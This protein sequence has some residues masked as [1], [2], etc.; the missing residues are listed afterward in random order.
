MR[1]L[2]SIITAIFYFT[3]GMLFAQTEPASANWKTW[4]VGSV[5]SYRLPAPPSSKEEIAQVLAVQQNLDSAGW[6]QLLF[7]NAG[8]PGYRWHEM[9]A[10]IWQMD[11]GRYGALANMLL[12]TSIYDATVAAWDS[13]YAYNRPRPFAADKR[14][15]ALIY[16]PDSPSYPCEHSVA[17][18][19]AVAVFSH[20]YPHLAD[21]VNRMAQRAMTS[22]MATG[23]AFPSDV[24]AGFEL[25]KRIALKEIEQTQGYVTKEVWDGKMPTGTQ[26]WKGKPMHPLAGKN[27]TVVLD[28]SSQFRP[29]APPDFAKDM[30]ELKA[31]KQTFRSQA[32]AF[33]YASQN[34]SDDILHKKIFEYN[35]HLHPPKAARI[36][37]ATAVAYYETFTACW[38]AKYAYWGLRPNQYDTTYKS[39]LPT[40]P[41]PGY[42]S[43]H[44]M[45][46]GMTGELFSYFFPADRALFQ[47]MAKDGAES[48][49][50][51]GIHFRT[52]NEVG[53]DMGRKVAGAIIRRLKHDGADENK[54]TDHRKLAL[55]KTP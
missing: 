18:G 34:T 45:M 35:L 6:Q 19:A 36:Y 52:D 12:G 24:Q 47:K 5:K 26:Y 17:A 2:F 28:S 39:L 11:T 23:V 42:P 37:A 13:K 16:K 1:T 20:F 55:V 43:G 21:S 8:S 29:I 4:F 46:G 15:A 50:H 7:W 30:A 44:A 32:N 3:P 41:F 27:K 14:V 25:G 22:R 40:P 10:K 51:A 38:D 31:F 48:R 53:L 54:A 9:M 49:F 33:H